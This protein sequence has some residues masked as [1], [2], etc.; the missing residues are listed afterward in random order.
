MIKLHVLFFRNPKFQDKKLLSF[1]FDQNLRNQKF[2]LRNF[3]LAKI[4][5]KNGKMALSS[6]EPFDFESRKIV[7]S[8]NGDAKGQRPNSQQ[9]KKLSA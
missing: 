5:L 6:T 4:Q 7:G 2:N 8:K 3:G 1:G 9:I